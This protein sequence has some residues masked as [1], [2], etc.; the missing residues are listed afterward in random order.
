MQLPLNSNGNFLTAPISVID[1]DAFPF[2]Q[3]EC[4][5]DNDDRFKIINL[6]NSVSY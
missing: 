6:K 1:L 5:I 2:N 3:F 4:E